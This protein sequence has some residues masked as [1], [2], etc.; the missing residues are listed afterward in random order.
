MTHGET[1]QRPG[2]VTGSEPLLMYLVKQLELAVRSRL[3]EIIRP[4]GLTSLQYTALTVLERHPDMSTAQLAR[5]S[6][7]TPQSMA[8]MITALE[9]RGL[10]ER[11]RDSLDRRRLVVALTDAGRELLDRYRPAVANMEAQMT[12]GLSKSQV[13][14]LRQSLHTCHVNVSG[15]KT[16]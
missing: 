11:H 5:N 15:R 10:I 9:T 14:T 4:S 13:T 3:D 7:V 1:E 6:F 8:D 16:Y 12:A 2:S